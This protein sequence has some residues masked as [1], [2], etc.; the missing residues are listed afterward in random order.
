[1]VKTSVTRP[2]RVA[3]LDMQP[4]TPT[5]GGGR[6][7]LLGIWH[8]L[9]PE[10]SCQYIGSY[11]WPGESTAQRQL[12]PTLNEKLVPLSE[13][14]FALN[15][16]Y[17]EA[18]GGQTVIDSLFH[19]FGRLSDDYVAAA[20]E[21]IAD[22][23][24]VCFEHPWVYPL[25]ADLLQDRTVIYDSQ[26]VE[27]LLKQMG[28]SRSLLGIE[29]TRAVAMCEGALLDRADHVFAC[30]TED[31]NLFSMIYGV[32]LDR[33]D[34]APNGVFAS[35]IVPP[36]EKEAGGKRISAIFLGSGYGPNREAAMHIVEQL[37][38]A[39]PE[40][41][42]VLLGSVSDEPAIRAAAVRCTNVELTGSVSEE[43]KIRRLQHADI[44]INPMFSGSGTNIK[45][46][47]FM[48]AG[49]PVLATTTGARGVARTD[50]GGV[51]VRPVHELVGALRQIAVKPRKHLRDLGAANRQIVLD[52]FA[53]EDISVRVGKR[54]LE[55][56]HTR[57]ASSIDSTITPKIAP[58]I[59]PIKGAITFVSTFGIKCGIAGYAENLST[60]LSQ[61]GADVLIIAADTPLE[62]PPLLN[63][64]PSLNI[65][66]RFDNVEWRSSPL[67]VDKIVAAAVAHGPKS[68]F[69]VQ[70][71][72]AF[73]AFSDLLKLC[74]AALKA[75]LIVSVTLH[76]SAA[77]EEE[78]HR[79][80]LALG[81]LVFVHD[82]NEAVRLS[83]LGNARYLPFGIRDIKSI[84]TS[85]RQIAPHTQIGTF[86]FLRPHKG[87]GNLIEA[88]AIVRQVRPDA[89]LNAFCSLYP[90]EDSER[91]LERCKALISELKLEDCVNLDTTHHPMNFILQELSRSTLNILPYQDSSEGAS[92]AANDCLGARRPLLTSYSRIFEPL[93][94]IVYRC[95][96]AG[97][98]G[99]AL[100]ILNML[101]NRPAVEQLDKVVNDYVNDNNWSTIAA[102]FYSHIQGVRD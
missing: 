3:V 9:T 55:I 6:Q 80:L 17:M 79:E 51:M 30:S 89:V 2:I 94:H 68:Q 61:Q 10:I 90:A 4:I 76:N 13:P 70:Y 26:N 47:D 91:E 12:T 8:A 15:E 86:G 28:L 43:E 7:R 88:M 44:A 21:A 45:M 19:I 22:A 11:D 75:D 41:D 49:L 46:F 62:A 84:G 60:A 24:I 40:I 81:I 85:E 99:L 53:W 58:Y 1:M 56:H 73:Y 100:S 32:P 29:V 63:A 25:V 20:A 52:E 38:P 74:T 27:V 102:C 50:R 83:Q 78:K 95:S 77:M 71:H 98:K 82:R 101:A 72:P 23:D 35:Q 39:V 36:L 87:I 42:F 54:I 34:V 48:S 57:R 65:M 31:K 18:A 16:L 66:W 97:P 64:N 14:H 37:A 93:G 96:D 69:N 92:G 67:D 33:I 59:P 5:I